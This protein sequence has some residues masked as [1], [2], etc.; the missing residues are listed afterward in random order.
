M[1]HPFTC[2]ACG[3]LAECPYFLCLEVDGHRCE[4]CRTQVPLRRPSGD[5]VSEAKWP[6]RLGATPTERKA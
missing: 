2:A 6:T 5:V 1:P 4:L 3:R